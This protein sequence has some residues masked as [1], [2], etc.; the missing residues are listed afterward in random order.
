MI[1]NYMMA[2]GD[3]LAAHRHQLPEGELHQRLEVVQEALTWLGTPWHHQGRV[4]GAGVDCGMLPMEVYAACGLV[5]QL[6]TPEYSHDFHL[7]RGEEFYLQLVEEHASKVARP[8]LPGDLALFRFGRVLS[9]GAI[10]IAWPCII[11]SYL[12]AH[13]VVLDDAEANLDLGQRL[14]GIWSMWKGGAS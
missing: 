1:A 4:R 2:A 5:P 14:E 12:P 7:H 3:V 8:P 10:V 11:H 9:H 6:P 13:A